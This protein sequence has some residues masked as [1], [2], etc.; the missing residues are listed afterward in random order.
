MYE[1]DNEPSKYDISS[2]FNILY[3]GLY[4]GAAMINVVHLLTITYT[5]ESRVHSQ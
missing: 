2:S 3:T 5:H 4:K 1:E